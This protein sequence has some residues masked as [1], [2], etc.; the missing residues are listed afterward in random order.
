MPV[1]WRDT[2]R[3]GA[4]LALL[5][6]LV[7][8][9]SLPLLTAGAALSVGSL[10]IHRLLTAGRWPT[11]AECW[12]AFRARLVPGLAAGPLCVG[13]GWLILI[14][15]AALRRGAVPGG[16]A[17]IVAVLL[18]AALGAG[19]AALVAGLAG[20]A[21]TH[22]VCRARSLVAARPGVL[23]AA[24]GVVV[25]A[26]VLA[27]VVHPVLVPVLAGFVLFAVHAVLVRVERRLPG[28]GG[29]ASPGRLAQPAPLGPAQLLHP[30]QLEPAQLEPAPLRP[31][32]LLQPAQPTHPGAATLPE[33]ARTTR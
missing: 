11:A 33:I 1:D 15:V 32:Q 8:L 19:F 27:V 23:F 24:T 9:A 16:P 22:A 12:T 26:G 25:I 21:E 17:M 3:L 29:G 2:L 28:D 30:A 4:D 14:D 10:A 20:T 31:A 13:A 5:G 7:T 6:I 18:A